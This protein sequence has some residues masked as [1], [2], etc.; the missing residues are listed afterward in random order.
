MVVLGWTVVLMPIIILVIAWFQFLRIPKIT[1]A[2]AHLA[3]ALMVPA[4][5]S[6][7]QLCMAAAGRDSVPRN[8]RAILQRSA[9][10]ADR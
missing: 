1:K 3:F 6:Y 5:I 10:M 9:N 8:S 7:N 4:T 2:Q